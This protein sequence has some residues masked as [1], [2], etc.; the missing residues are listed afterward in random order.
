[1][2]PIESHLVQQLTAELA[3]AGLDGAQVLVLSAEAENWRYRVQ[4]GTRQ[5]ELS[6]NHREQ[7]WARETTPGAEKHLVSNDH[8]RIGVSDRARRQGVQLIAAAARDPRFPPR[9]PP[10]L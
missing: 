4:V 3:G 6:F 8:E 10:I 5:F 1:V 7:F 9:D 2:D